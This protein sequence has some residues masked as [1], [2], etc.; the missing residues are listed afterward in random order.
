MIYS[1]LN[2]NFGWFGLFGATIL[3]GFTFYAIFVN[4]SYYWYFVRQRAHYVPDY[5]ESSHELQQAR[6]WS[7][8]NIIG[9]TLLVLPVQLLIVFG[10]SRLYPNVAEHGYSYLLA[11]LIGAIAFAETAIYWLHR[12]LHVQP[13]YGWLHAVHHRFREPTSAIAYAFNPLDSFVQSLPYHVYVFIVPTN[14]WVYFALWMFSSFW[15]V[16]IHDRVRWSPNFLYAVVNHAG[17]HAAHHWFY[18]YNYGNY[19]T[20]WDKLCGTY[21]DPDR[22]PE[23]LF[24]VKLAS[25]PPR[26]PAAAAASPETGWVDIGEWR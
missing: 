10:W 12:S 3:F 11:S 9:N 1:W 20:F 8:R 21:C 2:G 15:A 14:V 13:F 16:M 17:C 19:F 5:R 7:I 25:A 6:L 22:L 24:A 26:L 23:K 4:L 18:R